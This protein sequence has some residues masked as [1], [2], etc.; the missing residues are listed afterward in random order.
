MAHADTTPDTTSH[1]PGSSRGEDVTVP[2][3]LKPTRMAGDATGINVF[4]RKPIDPRMP[5]LPP[6]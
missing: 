6:A 5:N 4:D 1:S 3:V 2:V